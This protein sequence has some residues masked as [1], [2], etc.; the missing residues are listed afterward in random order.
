ME[1]IT[2]Y[3]SYIGLLVAKINCVF[4]TLCDKDGNN[5]IDV[6]LLMFRKIIARAICDLKI[7]QK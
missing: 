6:N 4:H 1:S 2:H 3:Y 7:A 5:V